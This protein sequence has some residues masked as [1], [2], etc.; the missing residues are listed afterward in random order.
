MELVWNKSALKLRKS[1]FMAA[2]NIID[3]KCVQYMEEVVPVGLPTYEKSGKLRD[4]VRIIKPGTIVYTAPKARHDYYAVVNHQRGGN[5]DAKRMW[6]EVMKTRHKEDILKDV[7]LVVSDNTAVP[8]IIMN[9]IPLPVKRAKTVK[10]G[11]I[12]RT[13]DGSCCD[14]CTSLAGRYEYK[15]APKEVFMKH[16][17]CNC[18]C[19]YTNGKIRQDVWTKDYL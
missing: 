6:F 16:I 14:W 11:W 2:Q 10:T 12:E 8:T 15:S 3:R 7:R 9:Q 1:K 17:N 4:S 19:I 5:P 18:K 13:T